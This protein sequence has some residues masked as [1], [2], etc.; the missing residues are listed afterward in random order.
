MDMKNETKSEQIFAALRGIDGDLPNYEE[1]IYEYCGGVWD[2]CNAATYAKHKKAHEFVEKFRCE[3]RREFLRSLPERRIRAIISETKDMSATE[4]N[5]YLRKLFA[6]AD[7]K[8]T[9]K[10]LELQAGEAR[11]TQ[12]NPQAPEKPERIIQIKPPDSSPQ[13]GETEKIAIPKRTSA[14]FVTDYDRI[15]LTDEEIWIREEYDP[16]KASLSEKERYERYVLLAEL[17]HLPRRV[18]PKSFERL[19]LVINATNNDTSDPKPQNN[20]KND[21]KSFIISFLGDIRQF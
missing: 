3:H 5:N 20:L 2:F 6:Q 13:S 18:K 17:G 12:K 11:E 9:G 19:E 7:R 4:K 21:I 1:F 10:K 8:A 15:T 14:P 16:D